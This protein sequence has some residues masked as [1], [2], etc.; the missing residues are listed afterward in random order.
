MRGIQSYARRCA[1]MAP[2]LLVLA[3]TFALAHEGATGVVKERMELM[4]Q[5][6]K[7]AKLIS[8]MIKGKAKFDTAKAVAAAR[9]LVTTS[10]KIPDLFPKGSDGH[11][12]EALPAVWTDWDQFTGDAKDL[13]TVAGKLGET[14]ESNGDWKSDFAKVSEACKSCH[15]SFRMK[16]PGKHH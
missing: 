4:K 16:E 14:L 3:A 13:E 8:D 15:E 11:P 5:Q 12:S 9:D 7:D 1:M 10:Q 6:Q 2:W